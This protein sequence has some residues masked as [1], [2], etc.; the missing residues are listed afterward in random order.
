[1][2]KSIYT[3][4]PNRTKYLFTNLKRLLMINDPNKAL[5]D[6]QKHNLPYDKSEMAPKKNKLPV[7]FKPKAPRRTLGPM[8]SFVVSA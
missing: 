2:S 1:M 5:S 6:H 8:D 7:K 3:T 4:D